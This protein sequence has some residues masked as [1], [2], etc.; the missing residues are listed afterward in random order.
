MERGKQW[1]ILICILLILPKKSGLYIVSAGAGFIFSMMLSIQTMYDGVKGVLMFLTALLP[2]V[3]FYGGVIIE[4]AR[5]II[6]YRS[7]D[8][9]LSKRNYIF[10]FLF[11]NMLYIVGV[12]LESYVNPKCMNIFL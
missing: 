7:R 3:I 6:N 5:L 10:M 2:Q 1:I 11:L 9:M 8:K 4:T 12:L